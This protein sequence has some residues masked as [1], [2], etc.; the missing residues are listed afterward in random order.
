[1]R[2]F[3][4][5]TILGLVLAACGTVALTTMYPHPAYADGGGCSGS[6]C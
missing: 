4:A 3:L 5:I 1:M 2:K 6:G